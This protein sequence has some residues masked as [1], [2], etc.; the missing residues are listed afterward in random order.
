MSGRGALDK[1]FTSNRVGG[2]RTL[3][4]S[5]VAELSCDPIK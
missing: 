5:I 3:A 2:Q 1:I 4:G